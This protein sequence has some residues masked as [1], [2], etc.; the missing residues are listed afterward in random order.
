M[1]INWDSK[2][3][4]L[5]VLRGAVNLFMGVNPRQKC[6]LEKFLK[7]MNILFRNG[8]N[9][10]T[11][12][13]AYRT[14]LYYPRDSGSGNKSKRSTSFFGGGGGFS[15]GGKRRGKTI[16]FWC[17]SPGVAM[18]DIYKLGVRSIILTSGTLSPMDSVESELRLPF[19]VRLENSHVVTETGLDRFPKMRA[20]KE[21]T[22]ISV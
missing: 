10:Q 3:A 8:L 13:E 21:T 2:D 12:K 6:H 20:D 5:Q 17:F 22:D 19:K 14:H 9:P 16:A 1:N 4:L 15:N 18:I 7:S 11:A